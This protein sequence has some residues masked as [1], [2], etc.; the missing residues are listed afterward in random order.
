MSLRFGEREMLGL[1]GIL[2]ITRTENSLSIH[3]CVS[4]YFVRRLVVISQIGRTL[5]GTTA[6]R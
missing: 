4:V 1:I 5:P 3:G 6:V 2:R